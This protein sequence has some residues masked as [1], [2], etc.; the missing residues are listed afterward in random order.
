MYLK[1]KTRIKLQRNYLETKKQEANYESQIS[2]LKYD[3]ESTCDT[4]RDWNNSN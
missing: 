4:L 3:K 2:R 1:S